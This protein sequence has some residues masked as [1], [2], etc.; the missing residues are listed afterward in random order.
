MSMHGTLRN[1]A[2][3][4]L[5]TF[6][7]CAL[8]C[9]G[10]GSGSDG[11][12]DTCTT[13][14]ECDDTFDCTEDGC[15]V[16]NTCRHTPISARCDMGLV[17][18]VDRGCVS[19][20]SCMRVEDCDDGL[21]CTL[22]SCGVGGLCGHTALDDL[23]SAPTTMCDPTM[24]CIVPPGCSSDTECDDGVACTND[25]CSVD[26][27]C[28]N[29]P[30]D[31]LCDET[32]MERCHET[33]GCF[34]PMPCATAADC[35]DGNFCNGAEICDAEFGCTPADEPRVCDDSDGCTMDSCDA[36]TDMCVFVCDT[37]RSECECPVDPPS[38]D[39]NFRITASTTSYSCFFGGVNLNWS[40]VVFMNDGGI[41][42]AR[43]AA[44]H[45]SSPLTDVAAPVCPTFSASHVV[46][47]GCEET[48]TISGTFT[49]ADNFTGMFSAAFRQTDG[50]SCTGSG[51]SNQNIMIT[52]TR[53]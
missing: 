53:I 18:E 49:D 10:G 20:A 32:M 42:N 28:T 51:C 47:G 27:T 13:D 37:S 17:C 38:C 15:N 36:G 41:L 48:Y 43:L 40:T 4:A 26:R 19:S 24:G 7:L 44:Q 45:F 46:P 25:S 29:T 1:L 12:V 35:D 16:D 39:G 30:L 9:A 3:V 5:T 21:A 22:D 33:R 52:G 2:P 14:L 34:V 8:G 11:S 6:T 50:I 31:V 23:C